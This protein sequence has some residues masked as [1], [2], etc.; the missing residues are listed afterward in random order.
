MSA[1]FFDTS[2]LF[3]LRFLFSFGPERKFVDKTIHPRRNE[4]WLDIVTIFS[5][6]HDQYFSRFSESL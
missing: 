5:G 3:C 4:N 1:Y 2:K 6:V